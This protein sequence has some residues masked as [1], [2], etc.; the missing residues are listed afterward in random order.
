TGAAS[1]I[2][3]RGNDEFVEP[4]LSADGRWLAFAGSDNKLYTAPFHAEQSIPETE[5]I[6]TAQRG[7][8]PAWAPDGNSIYFIRRGSAN[9]SAATMYRQPL[10]PATKRPVGAPTVFHRFDGFVFANGVDNPIVVAQD[11]IIL[12]MGEPNSDLWAIDLP[13]R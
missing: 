7:L 3:T 4:R 1:R 11:R 2:L 13:A 6:M 5:W 8:Q 12:F 9:A 10:D